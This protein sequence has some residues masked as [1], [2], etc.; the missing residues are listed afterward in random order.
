M[1]KNIQALYR[2]RFD[3]VD[4]RNNVWKVL[5]K[6]FFQRFIKNTDTVLDI[7]AGYCEF[8]NNI[9]ADKKIA[10]D[11][12]PDIAN[13]AH[14]DV[15]YHNIECE[16]LLDYVECDSIDVV[17][18]SNFFEHLDN[19]EELINVFGDIY[20][21]L[22]PGGKLLV[23]QPNIRYVK[24]AYWDFIDH[25]IPITDKSIIEIGKMLSFE[26]VLN[27]PKFLPYTTKTKMPIHP[28]FVH[29]YLMLIP[30]SSFLMGKQ[31]F[32]I[33]EK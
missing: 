2:T 12:N 26:T 7:A 13:Y 21:V 9:S 3:N 30:F 18:V 33:L 8:I 5:C 25:K 17:F 6:S 10:I 24:S 11:I 22:K 4:L 29:L 31:S 15:E 32:T 19:R 1:L 27:M 14:N 23:L 16:K 20:K 28:I